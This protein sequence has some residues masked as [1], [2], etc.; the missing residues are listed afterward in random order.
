MD[1]K[2]EVLYRVY[3]LLFGIVVPVAVL[4]LYR[5]V[6]IS[7][8]QGDTWRE[9]GE[10]NYVR[11]KEIPA[12][13]GNIFS[14]DGSLLATSI[15]YFDLYFDPVAPNER[16][17]NL[18][19]DSLAY[20][21][22]TYIDDT[23]T[24]GGLRDHLIRLRQDSTNRHLMIKRKVSY[25]EKKFI[26]SFPLFRLG[27]FRGGI[28]PEQRSDRRRPFG[29]LAQ[30][31]IGYVRDGAKPVGIEGYFEPYLQGA[32]GGQYMIC[33]DRKKDIWLPLQDLS[34]IDPTPGDDVITTIDINVQDIVE[35]ALLRA[36]NYHEADWGTAIL[37]KVETGA[38]QAIANLGKSQEGWW[39]TYNHAVG[40]SVE[41]GSTF[42]LASMMAMLEDGFVRLEDSIDIEKGKT[43]FYEDVMVDSSPESEHIDTTSVRQVFH[44]SSNVG[45][46][47][48]VNQAYGGQGDAARFIRRLQQFNLHIPTGIEIEGEAAP[49]IK[50]AYS[51]KDRWSGTTLPWMAIG[52]ESRITPLQLLTF[53]NAVANNGTMMQPYL[54]SSIQ[55]NGEELESFRPTIIKRKIA[56]ERTIRLA[57][58]LLKGVVLDGTAKKLFTDRYSFAG[59][60]GTAQINYRRL[61]A[62]R[63][64]IGGYRASFIGYFPADNPVYSCIVVIHNPRA[65][66]YYGSDVAGPVFREIAD[67]TYFAT[68]DIH[69]P[70]NMQPKPKLATAQ[71]PSYDFGQQQDIRKVMEYMDLPVYGAPETDLVMLRAKTDSVFLDKKTLFRGQVPNVIGLGLKDALFVLE[72]LGLQVDVQGVGKVALQSIRPGTPAQ[73][74]RIKLTLQ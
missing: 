68:L 74:Q 50:E 35:N 31:T 16:D 9:Q 23:Y 32:P 10:N 59:K 51:Q 30:R 62:E 41:P 24:V 26:E 19:I 5:T 64:R 69:E 34:A 14:A 17:F 6:Q 22:A 27:Q 29:V 18:Y 63:T 38:I 72:N 55:R 15:P 42:K 73:R 58:E 56:S 67:K 54:V 70:V 71:L 4:L 43:Q 20:C 40:T 45:M 36:L 7:I 33:V 12:D 11:Y 3:F 49:Y 66:G 25:A 1:I 37:M 57:Q 46:A 53:Y 28:I 44:M 61:S 60:T 65:H 13:R 47:K 8:V 48:L 52:Y 39:E 2:N 21:W